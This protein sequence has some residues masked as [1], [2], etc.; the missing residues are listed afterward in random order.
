MSAT[1][2]TPEE[3]GAELLDYHRRH[4]LA[5]RELARFMGYRLDG[6]ESDVRALGELLPMVAFRPRGGS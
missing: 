3:A 1:F 2:L 6:S 5:L 4:P